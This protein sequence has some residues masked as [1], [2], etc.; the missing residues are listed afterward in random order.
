MRLVEESAFSR[1]FS[2]PGLS[3]CRPEWL[4]CKMIFA[5]VPVHG[6]P[7]SAPERD[8]IVAV[9]HGVVRQDAPAQMHRHK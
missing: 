5:V 7:N 6:L 1:K 2:M 4:N 9:D 8:F 3:R